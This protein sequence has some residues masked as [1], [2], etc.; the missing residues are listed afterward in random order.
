MT[1][2]NISI[3]TFTHYN[4]NMRISQTTVC[5]QGIQPLPCGNVGVMLSEA[6]G[7]ILLIAK[8]VIS[9]H[10]KFQISVDRSASMEIQ[11]VKKEPGYKIP[12]TTL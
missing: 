2:K 7:V 10:T 9:K 6:D 12:M 11:C 8:S 3:Q 5:E 4:F 1:H